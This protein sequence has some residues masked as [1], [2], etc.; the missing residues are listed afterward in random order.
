MEQKV[1][2]LA[3][4]LVSEQTGGARRLYGL[5]IRRGSLRCRDRPGHSPSIGWR[6]A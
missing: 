1:Y 2:A 4:G 6:I 3:D 5:R